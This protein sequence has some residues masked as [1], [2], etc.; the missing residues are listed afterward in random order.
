APAPRAARQGAPRPPHRTCR[1][2]RGRRRRGPV[3]RSGNRV[4]LLKVVVAHNE[5][6]SSRP[7]G[8]N[9]V[10]AGDIANLTAA[11]VEVIDFRRSSDEIPRLPMRERLTLPFS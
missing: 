1:L 6:V 3:P 11:G 5:D 7:S 9:T 8:E 4:P 2:G 10:V